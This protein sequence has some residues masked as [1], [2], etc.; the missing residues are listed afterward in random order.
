MTGIILLIPLSTATSTTI[1]SQLSLSLQTSLSPRC[2]PLIIEEEYTW[3]EHED[4]IRDQC[5][6][7]SAALVLDIH[8]GTAGPLGANTSND[9]VLS[10][11]VQVYSRAAAVEQRAGDMV[12]YAE[13]RSRVVGNKG[14]NFVIDLSQDTSSHFAAVLTGCTCTE[15]IDLKSGTI[16]K[17]KCYNCVSPLNSTSMCLS[18]HQD[19]L[20]C[21][22][23]MVQSWS[24][25]V[26]PRVYLLMYTSNE[27]R[28]GN[29]LATS[30]ST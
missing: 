24:P 12:Q 29:T 8:C 17:M 23:P 19:T 16:Y 9:I 4:R 13:V 26:M 5:A 22:D 6:T 30:A 7:S 10:L 14:S 21:Q 28:V 2:I 3:I 18:I 20:S 25:S 27:L 1:D 15:C 11:H